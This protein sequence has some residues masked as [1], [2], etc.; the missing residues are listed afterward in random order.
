MCCKHVLCM[1]NCLYGPKQNYIDQ[2]DTMDGALSVITTIYSSFPDL[3]L[4]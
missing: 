2:R 4:Y 1:P 3:N